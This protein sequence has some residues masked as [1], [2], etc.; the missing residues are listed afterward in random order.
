M[1]L[2]VR[3]GQGAGACTRFDN[4]WMIAMGLSCPTLRTNLRYIEVARDAPPKRLR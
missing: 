4:R 1:Q 2:A 3:E